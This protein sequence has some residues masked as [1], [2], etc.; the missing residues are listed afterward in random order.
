MEVLGS[1]T[2]GS[3]QKLI[4]EVPL[5]TVSQGTTYKG[6]SGKTGKGGEAPRDENEDRTGAPG[7]TGES[8]EDIFHVL[9]LT[10]P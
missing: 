10:T 2:S 8:L 9:E 1:Y 6:G 4:Q 5:K 3:R 7:A